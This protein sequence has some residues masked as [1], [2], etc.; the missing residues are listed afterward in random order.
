M[1]KNIP[2]LKKISNAV[3]IRE[4]YTR[5]SLT[6]WSEIKQMKG[7]Y[8]IAM[9]IL[10]YNLPI[11]IEVLNQILITNNL[12][13]TQI[14]LDQ[15]LN[16]PKVEY[17]NLNSDSYK[18]EDFIEKIGTVRNEKYP[19][20]V[21]I[22]THISTGNKYVGSSSSLARRLI[23]YFKGT[24][25]NT[26]KFIPFLNKQG[27]NAFKLQVIPIDNNIYTEGI[28]LCLEQY[29]LLNSEF[30]LNTLRIVNKISG[31]RS[32]PLYIYKDNILLYKANN[33]EEI[34]FGLNIHYTTII[35][36]IKENKPFLNLFYFY[37]TPINNAKEKVMSLDD[38]LILIEKERLNNKKGRK[39][40]LNSMDGKTNIS[41]NSI[42]DCLSY[43]NS[44]APSFKTTL[45]RYIESGKPYHGFICNWEEDESDNHSFEK[46]I[47]ISITDIETKKV[48]KINSI[49][50]AALWFNPKTTGQT[51]KSYLESGKLFRNKFHIEYNNSNAND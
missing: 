14:Q 5:R 35:N 37:S 48:I 30:N 12:N 21:Y 49:R 23:G 2:L 8:Y 33:Q 6:N 7:S 29:F 1:K 46:G 17:T 32:N 34:M 25:A 26:G 3:V 15:L 16:I 51:I 41:F 10:K 45:Y 13:I 18:R 50:K 40:L 36:C 22:W 43:L 9:N 39:L 4:Y 44:I 31:S 27:V 38:L 28:Q 20:G 11:T 42:Q 47:E 24:H 19:G